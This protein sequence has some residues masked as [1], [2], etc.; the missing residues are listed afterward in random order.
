MFRLMVMI[1]ML[2]ILSGCAGIQIASETSRT[3]SGENI[4]L[5]AGIRIERWGK[6]RF[7]G[8]L[9]VASKEER[10]V[11]ALLDGTG[12]TLLE[13]PLPGEGEQPELSGVLRDSDLAYYL[14]IAFSR[15]FLQEPPN[16]PC[17]RIFL[18]SLCLDTEGGRR[19]AKRFK[20]GP[21][22]RW[23]VTYSDAG[24]TEEIVY[25]EPWAGVRITI[26]EKAM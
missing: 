24:T 7:S 2:G 3:S 9:A 1:V 16:E 23:S 8:I 4:H 22:T 13:G 11:F 25:S 12:V 17:S 6:L 18:Q 5:F 20:V 10:L 15:I 21:F 14:A 26:N 19:M